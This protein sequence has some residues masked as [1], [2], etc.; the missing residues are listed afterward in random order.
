MTVRAAA[1][2]TRAI[3]A[4]DMTLAWQASSA[5]AGALLLVDRARD[6]L[7]RLTSPPRP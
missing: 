4:D 7:D 2:R 5:A 3:T 1:T 6:E